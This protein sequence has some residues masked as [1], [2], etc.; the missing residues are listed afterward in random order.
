MILNNGPV[1]ES[2]IQNLTLWEFRN[3]QL[4]GVQ[5]PANRK[6]QRKFLKPTRCSEYEPGDPGE[7]CANSTATFDDIQACAGRPSYAVNNRP[8]VAEW[9]GAQDMLPCLEQ[10]IFQCTDDE[11]N[12]SQH[13]IHSKVCKRCH[14]FYAEDGI[15]GRLQGIARFQT[16]LCR[17]HSLEQSKQSPLNACRCVDYMVGKRKCYYCHRCTYDYLTI[18]HTLFRDSIAEARIPWTRPFAL[19]RH[20]LAPDRLVCPI[21]GCMRNSW[22]DESRPERMQM[23]LGCNSITR[24]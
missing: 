9:L 6:L 23:C 2:V 18:R 20:Y 14:E 17:L 4:A 1:Q 5:I 11:P 24:L 16:P 19:L 8:N 10:V 15:A 12:T 22:L 13:P 7:R 21:E 3:L